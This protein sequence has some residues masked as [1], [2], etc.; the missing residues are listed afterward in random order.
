[1]ATYLVSDDYYFSLGFKHHL[2]TLQ[3]LRWKDWSRLTTEMFFKDGDTL[4]LDTSTI[5]FIVKSIL[6]PISDYKVKIIILREKSVKF[7]TFFHEYPKI[8]KNETAKKMIDMVYQIMSTSPA[9]AYCPGQLTAQERTILAMIY[10]QLSVC[11]ISS[12]LTI[13]PKTVSAH[14]NNALRK[15]KIRRIDQL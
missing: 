4:I 7:P 14:K 9:M 8:M 10:R 12:Q 2:K 15:L 13:H 3:P 1:M 6:M 5:D 11:D